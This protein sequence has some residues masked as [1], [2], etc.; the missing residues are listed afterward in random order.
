VIRFNRCAID[1]ANA[2]LS[3]FAHLQPGDHIAYKPYARFELTR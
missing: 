2:S 1:A 3:K